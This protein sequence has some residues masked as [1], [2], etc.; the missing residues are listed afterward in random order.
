MCQVN[1]CIYCLLILE[2]LSFDGEG[3]LWNRSVSTYQWNI[4]KGCTPSI[5]TGPCGDH[6]FLRSIGR[7]TWMVIIYTHCSGGN[8]DGDADDVSGNCDGGGGNDDY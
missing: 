6:T 8:D 1:I 4:L 2:T 7:Y 5:L 3:Y